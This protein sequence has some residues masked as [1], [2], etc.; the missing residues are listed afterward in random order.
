VG[1]ISS[2]VFIVGSGGPL[3]SRLPA[4]ERPGRKRARAIATKIVGAKM[5]FFCLPMSIPP[6][7]FNG[8]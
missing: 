5:D 3:G 8:L 6:L 2:S 7:I 4:V 1:G